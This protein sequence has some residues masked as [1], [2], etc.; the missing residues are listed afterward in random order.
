MRAGSSGP[1]PKTTAGRTAIWRERKQRGGGAARHQTSRPRPGRQTGGAGHGLSESRPAVWV[2]AC[3]DYRH[4][5]RHHCHYHYHYSLL[6]Y[7][8]LISFSR[9]YRFI[10]YVERGEGAGHGRGK[11]YASAH[12]EH[13]LNTRGPV[14][15]SPPPICCSQHGQCRP[16]LGGG[17][18]RRKGQSAY[19]PVRKRAERERGRGVAE[20]T[21]E[22][23]RR[24]NGGV[25]QRGTRLS[26]SR[27]GRKAYASTH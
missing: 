19:R 27:R 3:A 12:T 16:A 26:E 6:Y 17:G 9:H 14:Q 10:S 5:H 2:L 15:A 4:H 1:G 21:H 11:A 23:P 25:G 8:P 13:I 7:D 22:H 20:G 18:G 24:R